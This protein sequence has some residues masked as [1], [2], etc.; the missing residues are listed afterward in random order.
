MN[1]GLNILDHT[2]VRYNQTTSSPQRQT[3][4]V[5]HITTVGGHIT[6][7]GVTEEQ[8]ARQTYCD[9]NNKTHYSFPSAS[10]C[11]IVVSLQPMQIRLREPQVDISYHMSL[12]SNSIL[13]KQ[14]SPN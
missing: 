11:S 9:S 1:K 13:Y 4:Q 6:T 5:G 7:A 2:T 12:G 3:T 10:D 14:T 8:N